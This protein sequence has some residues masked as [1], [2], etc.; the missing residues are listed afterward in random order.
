MFHQQFQMM[1]PQSAYM[2]HLC[3]RGGPNQP[4]HRDP[5]WS[6]VLHGALGFIVSYL[7]ILDFLIDCMFFITTPSNV[8]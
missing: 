4:L 7:T 3:V 1:E 2:E 8:T 5:Q 6:I